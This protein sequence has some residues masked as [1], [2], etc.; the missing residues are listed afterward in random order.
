[1]ISRY[2]RL[3][4]LCALNRSF[5]NVLA[6]C[7]ECAMR[8]CS[9]NNLFRPGYVLPT[10]ILPRNLRLSVSA[11]LSDIVTAKT[12]THVKLKKLYPSHSACPIIYKDNTLYGSMAQVILT[13]STGTEILSTRPFLV[14]Y[15]IF[16]YSLGV[17]RKGNESFNPRPFLF[18]L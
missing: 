8:L 16:W 18:I 11:H 13:F 17:R 4:C 12:K 2:L 15:I 6:T 14:A 9:L 10:E 7:S 3:V 5:K 1:M